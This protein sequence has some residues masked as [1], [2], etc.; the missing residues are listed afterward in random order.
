VD[1]FQHHPLYFCWL[2]LH[3]LL[4]SW[5]KSK[6]TNYFSLYTKTHIIC[7]YNLP[8]WVNNIWDGMNVVELVTNEWQKTETKWPP[9]AKKERIRLRGW[10]ISKRQLLLHPHSTP[11]YIEIKKPTEGNYSTIEISTW[12]TKVTST[13][14]WTL[15]FATYQTSW[16]E[17]N[18]H[19]EK[20]TNLTFWVLVL[21]Q[22]IISL[23]WRANSWNTR[24]IIYVQRK[25]D[26]YQLV[27]YQILA[28]H[29]SANAVPQLL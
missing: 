18:F 15:E 29:F 1:I 9:L 3:F 26:F 14:L 24:F 23:R 10:F 13:V 5:G 16:W 17:S 2:Y 20:I 25:F 27:W 6:K 21:H 22:R 12:T 19:H 8:Y 7:S 28:F 4:F 11:T